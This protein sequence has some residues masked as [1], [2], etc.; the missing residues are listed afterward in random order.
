MEELMAA[1]I[2]DKEEGDVSPVYCMNEGS[3]TFSRE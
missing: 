3:T 1:M 2:P